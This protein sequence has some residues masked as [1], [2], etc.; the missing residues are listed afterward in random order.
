MAHEFSAGRLV[1][2]PQIPTLVGIGR[3]DRNRASRILICNR[4]SMHNASSGKGEMA[5][6][7]TPHIT[8]EGLRSG[9]RTLRTA[10]GGFSVQAHAV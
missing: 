4:M 8:R 10:S 6:E 2:P 1:T 7:Q 3:G 5:M 9:S